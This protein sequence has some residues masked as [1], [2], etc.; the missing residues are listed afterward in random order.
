M[1]VSWIHLRGFRGY[2]N[3]QAIWSQNEESH[4][5]I[6]QVMQTIQISNEESSHAIHQVPLH[7]AK[8]GM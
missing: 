6:H 4:S 5:V 2:I 1:T 7:S 3:K 8:V